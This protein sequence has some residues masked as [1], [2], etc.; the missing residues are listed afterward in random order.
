[1]TTEITWAYTGRRY[2]MYRFPAN[3]E[4]ELREL[5]R[6]DNW[7][8]ALAWVE[9]ACWM[10]AC[11][12]ACKYLTAWLY[13]LAVLIIGARQRGTSTLLHDCAHGVG[14]ANRRLQMVLGTVFTAYPIFQKHYAYKVSHVLTHHPKLGSPTEDP[15]L[16]F[17][18]EQRAYEQGSPR[19]YVRRVVLLPLLGSQTWGYLR[20]LVRNRYQVITGGGRTAAA[21]SPVQQ[22][23]LVLDRIAFW[24]FWL[25][26]VGCAWYGGWLVGLLLFWVV[27]YLTSFQILGWYIELSEHTPL[28]R[29]SNVDLYM[30]R[31]RKSR[32]WE[33]LLTGIHNDNYHLEHHLDPR[34][35][36][37]RLHKARLIR[38]QDENYRAV[39]AQFGGL[40]TRG[41]QGQ[42]S[43]MTAIIT[44]MTEPRKVT[45]NVLV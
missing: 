39:D 14:V 42:Q 34:T 5:N 17:F 25:L 35:P 3:V 36:Y 40:F 44:S 18:I 28:V 38:L 41:P 10:A 45:T 21:K 22:R 19:S 1:M 8:V 27:P 20:Y 13:P 43:A 4:R 9:D 26:V 16:R 31:N 30:T 37:Y 29:D 11:I 15:D 24:A 2:E 23:K 32:G 6:P 7:H 33:K 12:L